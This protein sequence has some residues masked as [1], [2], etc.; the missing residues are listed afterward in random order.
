M[1]LYIT[2]GGSEDLDELKGLLGTIRGLLSSDRVTVFEAPE[3]LSY[4]Y[5]FPMVTISDDAS[6]RRFYGKEAIEEL[7]DL[8]GGPRRVAG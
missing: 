1:H 3:T 4:P 7:R 5:P 2:I 6:R 8:A